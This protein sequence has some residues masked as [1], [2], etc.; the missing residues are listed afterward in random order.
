[1]SLKTDFFDG[2]TGL[3]QKLNDSFTAGGTFVTTNLATLSSSL[4]SNA[5]QGNTKFT[6]TLPV[7]FQPAYIRANKGD[8]LL[9]KSF[10]AGIIDGL[11][12]QQIYS[13]E[14]AVAL[15]LVDTIDV[16]VD[17]FFNFQTA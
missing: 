2:A 4:V 11:A 6:V 3:H 7:T 14:V 1:M 9:A 5:A 15:N 13:Y 10:F 8:N 12:G 16:K 17:L